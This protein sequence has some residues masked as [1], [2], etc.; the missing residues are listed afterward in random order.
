MR[1]LAPDSGG[2]G[3]EAGRHMS[4][5]SPAPLHRPAR[6]R[7][8]GAL[9]AN[10]LAPLKPA[11]T[12]HP[13]EGILNFPDASRICRLSCQAMKRQ[14]PGKNESASTQHAGHIGKGNRYGRLP[15]ASCRN[16]V[17]VTADWIPGRQQRREDAPL[18]VRFRHR[19][20]TRLNRCR[21]LRTQRR[22]RRKRGSP[23]DTENRY[24]C[25]FFDPSSR[26]PHVKFGKQPSR[27]LPRGHILEMAT[28]RTIDRVL[29]EEGR[30]RTTLESVLSFRGGAVIPRRPAPLNCSSRFGPAP[31]G[32]DFRPDRDGSGDVRPA[33]TWSIAVI[34][35]RAPCAPNRSRNKTGTAVLLDLDRRCRRRR[36]IPYGP[37]AVSGRAGA[38]LRDLGARM[39]GCRHN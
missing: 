39:A 14:H 35:G 34:E 7:I 15:R 36:N 10:V 23:A 18:A 33:S 28:S 27:E 25:G 20:P 16:H 22:R 30:A 24:R 13:R 3:A 19:G 12:P 11:A 2:V 6:R 17:R 21:C 29:L 5:R 37:P 32:S 38:P 9:K 4:D 8:I 31:Y 26:T 1:T